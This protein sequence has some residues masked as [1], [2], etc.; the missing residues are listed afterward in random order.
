MAKEEEF[1]ENE[2]KQSGDEPSGAEPVSKT[3][4]MYIG[5]TGSGKSTTANTM[6]NGDNF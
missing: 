5:N 1:K 3:T 6:V 4:I 2:L